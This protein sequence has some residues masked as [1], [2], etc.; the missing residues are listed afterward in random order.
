MV[1]DS[2]T[3]TPRSWRESSREPEPTKKAEGQGSEKA[4]GS[5]PTKKAEGSEPTEV[6]KVEKK[7][8]GSEP[9]EV[10]KAEKKAAEGSEPTE[11]DVAEKKAEKK[12]GPEKLS[13]AERDERLSEVRKILTEGGLVN[14][15]ERLMKAAA[16]LYKPKL[17]TCFL[18]MGFDVHAFNAF[19]KKRDKW[20]RAGKQ[21]SSNP[22]KMEVDEAK[23]PSPAKPMLMEATYDVGEKKAVLKHAGEN[24]ESSRLEPKSK[25]QGSSSQ[26]IAIFKVPG[27]DEELHARV[28]GIWW[29]LVDP[30]EPK[31]HQA[32]ASTASL[33]PIGK[34]KLG[35]GEF[36][37]KACDGG[38]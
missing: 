29:G 27:F 6:L 20:R 8:E 17:Q 11:A 13:A 2:P 12:T 10:L 30:K 21:S 4:E 38:W 16:G 5:E 9:T 33:R 1:F 22:D 25:A 31:E 23:A 15:D 36:R 3:A 18:N 28:R 26:V 14:D 37:A 19:M 24:Y 35:T 7:A 34:R 32:S